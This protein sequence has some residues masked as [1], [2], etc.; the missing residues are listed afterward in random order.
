MLSS[1][2]GTRLKEEDRRVCYLAG[3]QK[4]MLSRQ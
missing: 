3:A 1:K 4:K 2:P